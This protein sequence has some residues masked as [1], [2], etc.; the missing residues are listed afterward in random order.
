MPTTESRF[1]PHFFP[2]TEPTAEMDIRCDRSG[3]EI[4]I[5]EGDD[6][7]EILG[8]GMVHPNVLR[9]CNIDPEKYQ[10]FAFGLGVDRLAMLKYGMPDLRPYFE[11][12]VEW[13]THYGFSPGCCRP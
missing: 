8:C 10:G 4:K 9:S 5:G 2:F 11:A 7:L 13:I 1:R 12:D 6:W 3:A